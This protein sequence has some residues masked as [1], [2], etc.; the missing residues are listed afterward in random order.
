MTEVSDF[1][2]NFSSTKNFFKGPG[3]YNSDVTSYDYDAPM[4]E[5]GKNSHQGQDTSTIFSGKNWKCPILDSHQFSIFFNKFSEQATQQK[6]ILQS[7]N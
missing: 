2:N 5:A 6:N 1:T 4:D 7:E 3:N